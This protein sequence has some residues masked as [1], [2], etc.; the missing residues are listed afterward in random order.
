MD[1]CFC[2]IMSHVPSI[3]AL[4]LARLLAS[5]PPMMIGYGGRSIPQR[6]AAKN[7]EKKP[8][9]SS[10]SSSRDVRSVYIPSRRIVKLDESHKD[11]RQPTKFGGAMVDPALWSSECRCPRRCIADMW[12]ALLATLF[13]LHWCSSMS[14]LT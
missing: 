10:F 3:A 13:S 8:Y 7:K 4:P 12:K 11:G 9:T 5:G 1:H 2:S 6:D 14:D